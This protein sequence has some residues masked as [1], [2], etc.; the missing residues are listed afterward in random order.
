MIPQP[1]RLASLLLLLPLCSPGQTAKIKI[2]IDHVI[3]RIDPHIYGVFME[4]INAHRGGP[5]F[6]T[7]YGPVYDPGSPLADKEGFRTD[8]VQAARELDLTQMR[9]PGGNFTA[10]YDWRNGVG[11]KAARPR[12]L[13]L[14]WGGVETNQVGTDEWVELNRE[15]GSDDI[16]CINAG[17]GTITE[18]ADW[19]AYCNA[20]VGT[21]WADKRAAN[22][23][24]QPYDIRIWDLGNE[25]DGAPWIIGHKTAGDYVKFAVEAAKAMRAS[26]PGTKLEFVA[27]GS[28]YYQDNLDWV[29]WNWKVIRGLY[30]VADYLSIH[31]YWGASKDYYVLLGQRDRELE[32]KI[33]ITAGQLKAVADVRQGP[34][35]YLSVDEWAPPFGSG[36]LSA[37]VLAEYFNAFL[38]H[39]DVVKMANYTLLTS[40]LGRD[41]QTGRTYK[42]PLFYAFKLFSAR[43][44]GEALDPFV[45]CGTFSTGGHFRDLPFLDVSSVYNPK[46]GQVMINVV[47]RHREK[48]VATDISCITGRF[49]RTAEASTIAA[50]GAGD[51]P[52]TYADRA[53]YPPKTEQI[54]TTGS[55]IHYAFPAHSFT[56]IVVGLSRP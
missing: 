8:I 19:V 22:G 56:Q 36:S 41:G 21:Y 11:P 35:M 23:H 52:Y 46:T 12:L 42:T 47:N 24:P 48:S 14:A 26:S 32:E 51:Q 37:L 3:S 6:S 7:L 45:E 27:S 54:A 28:S 50:A 25:V 55:A 43:C 13:N 30:G 40:I 33:D 9:W 20:P 39:A 29:N 34:P 31:R 18:A 38:R 16:V 4:P 49:D 1:S 10:V 44:R 5:K 53:D 17:T 15:I 2:D